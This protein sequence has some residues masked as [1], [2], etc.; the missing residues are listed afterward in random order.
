MKSRI[1]STFV[2]LGLGVL[3]C[4]GGNTIKV[5]LVA[6][7]TGEVRT[8]GQSMRNGAM[9]AFDEVNAAGG[10][11]GRQIQVMVRDDANDPEESAEAGRQ[12]IDGAGVVAVVGSVSSGC[13]E[14]LAARCQSA[15]V[16]MIT[17]TA[18]NP[19]VTMPP[20]GR[21][22]FVFRACYIDPF[23]GTVA[24]RFV[25]DS[26]G[27]V[28][29][30]V[31]YDSENDYS[32][33]L[34]EYFITAFTGDGGTVVNRQSYPDDQVDFTAVLAEVR[35]SS[36]DVLFLPDYYNRAGLIVRQAREQGVTAWLM[37][38]DG[39][40]SP[41]MPAIAGDAIVGGFFT[42]HFS[43]D[44]PRPEVQAWSDKYEAKY[45]QRPDAFATLGYDAAL[46]LVEALRR[47]ARPEPADIRDA[48]AGISGFPCV[49]GSVSFDA[50]G[51]P[52]KPAVVLQYAAEGQRYIATVAP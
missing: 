27:A 38:G 31:L 6:P 9:Q 36:P 1:V 35:R 16:P 46:L 8:F 4:A 24:A 28:T 10:L 37:G 42:S 34:A 20:E 30:A 21:R 25:R 45:G 44:D 15:R 49:S 48:I 7:L 47:A 33:G 13:S 17:P 40:D 14:A 50:S 43:A 52:I 29:A 41:K 23:Q 5:G 32:R 11:N 39:W 3:A 19:M 12:L 2:F 18:T 51:N 22:D 26:L